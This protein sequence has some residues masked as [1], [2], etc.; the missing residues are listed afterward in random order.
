MTQTTTANRA[1][2]DITLEAVQELDLHLDSIRRTAAALKG[3][4]AMLYPETADGDF[5]MNMTHVSEVSAVFGFFGT[6]L[7]A[8]RS[9]ADET[10][11]RIRLMVEGGAA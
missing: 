3:I 4:G 1:S 7:E 5:Q 10:L 8:H 6:A 11:N 9:A 2:L